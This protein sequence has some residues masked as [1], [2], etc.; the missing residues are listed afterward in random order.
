MYN[1]QDVFKYSKDLSVLYVEDDKPLQKET[2]EIL[3]NF[4]TKVD[5]ASNGIEGLECYNSYR[6]QNN[7]C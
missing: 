3:E 6:K 1:F 4:F 7:K 2:S 5:L